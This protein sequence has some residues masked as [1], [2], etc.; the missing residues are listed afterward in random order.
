MCLILCLIFIADLP[1]T[2]CAV[3][4]L[5]LQGHAGLLEEE[6]QGKAVLS[7][8]TPSPSGNTT[9]GPLRR[10]EADNDRVCVSDAIQA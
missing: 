1:T 2:A 8:N 4:G 7:G 9:I 3:P 6:R 10:F 5:A